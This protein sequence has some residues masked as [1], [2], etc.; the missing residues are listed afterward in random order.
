[1]TE[2]QWISP[3]CQGPACLVRWPRLTKALPASWSW[4]TAVSLGPGPGQ[5]VQ[6]V[7]SGKWQGTLLPC[8]WHW[9]NWSQGC[10]GGPWALARESPKG[11]GHPIHR[12][13]PWPSAEGHPVIGRASRARGAADRCEGSC[14]SFA[15]VPSFF[16]SKISP[17]AS[18]PT[19]APGGGGGG[20]FPLGWPSLAS[21]PFQSPW[22]PAALLAD[23]P[24]DRL[25]IKGSG[26]VFCFLGGSL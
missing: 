7:E 14:L 5:A 22:G 2:K 4:G 10:S 20:L 8:P 19:D 15:G 24:G 18:Q 3:R 6:S 11:K 12:Q 17:G 13:V 16:L 23:A 26:C 21:S 9:G 1:M 25:Q